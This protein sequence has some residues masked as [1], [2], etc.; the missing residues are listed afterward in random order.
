M[1]WRLSG[2]TDAAHPATGPRRR[3]PYAL[4]LPV[5][6]R[7]RSDLNRSAGVATA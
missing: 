7:S 3:T 4:T 1:S 5:C 6:S 2:A